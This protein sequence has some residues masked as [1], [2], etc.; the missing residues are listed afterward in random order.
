MADHL[1]SYTVFLSHIH[2]KPLEICSAHQLLS[3]DFLLNVIYPCFHLQS[4]LTIITY[5]R[6]GNLKISSFMSS[7]L[8]HPIPSQ[9]HRQSS[10]ETQLKIK[11]LITTAIKTSVCLPVSYWSKGV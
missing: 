10:V 4:L 2:T 9:T 6:E 5:N 3:M 8:D 1:I 11:P 7:V